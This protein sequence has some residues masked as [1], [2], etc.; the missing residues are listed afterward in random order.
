LRKKIFEIKE[1]INCD[2]EAELLTLTELSGL[3]ISLSGAFAL[4]LIIWGAKK[5][6]RLDLKYKS[7][8]YKP[9]L[10][11]VKVFEE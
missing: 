10:D 5:L 11:K 6:L 4:A 8:F 3:W 9:N 1:L 7:P 2:S